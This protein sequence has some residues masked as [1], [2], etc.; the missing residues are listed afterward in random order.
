M[1][2]IERNEQASV[3]I[4]SGPGMA[5]GTL[6]YVSERLGPLEKYAPRPITAIDATVTKTRDSNQKH[7]IEVRASLSVGNH[8][9]RSHEVSPNL[10]T[11]LDTVQDR[12][13]RQLAELPHGRRGDHV[14]HHKV[15]DR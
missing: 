14:P 7:A 9:L 4:H 15:R 13:R 1:T 11:A 5:P 6:E 3:T 10:R 12:L 8:V 2:I